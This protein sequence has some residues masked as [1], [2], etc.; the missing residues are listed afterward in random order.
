MALFTH[1]PIV[2]RLRWVVL[3]AMLFSVIN[4]LA[5]Q[6]ES[7]WHHPET[8]IRGDGMSI[9][10]PTNPTF[11]FFLGHGWLAYL[12]ASV[13]YLA[14]VFFL[15]SILPRMVALIAAF[16]VLFGHFFGAANW[17]IV[18]WHLG[19]PAFALYG[20]LLG[21]ALAAAAFPEVG[22]AAV[23][24]KRLRWVMLAAIILDYAVTLFGQPA[25]YW[26]HPETVNEA[27]QLFRIFMLR[28][29]TASVLF[30]LFYLACA[31]LLVFNSFLD[32][33]PD[34]SLRLSLRPFLWRVHMALLPLETGDGSSGG[35]WNP[36]ER[37]PRAVGLF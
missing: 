19:M 34:R 20:A 35:L 1:D 23:A 16:A 4:T 22:K 29:W 25:S 2:K 33:R 36:A 8:A 30:E 32:A 17:L 18:R 10:N 12:G 5:G 27:D 21:A 31:F 3:A 9:A 7:Y 13:A 37:D 26:L 15:V 28:G 14:A 6:P 11:D 24:G